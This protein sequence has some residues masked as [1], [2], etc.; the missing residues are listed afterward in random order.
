MQDIEL[1]A[2]QCYEKN[3]KYFSSSQ[4]DL[5]KKIQLFN[6]A[7]A[8]A[9]VHTKYD[10]EYKDNYFDVK[11]LQYEQ[12]LYNEDSI[13]YALAV[14]DKINYNKKSFLFNAILDYHLTDEQIKK[15]QAKTELKQSS[16]KDVLPIMHY[17]MKTAPKTTTMKTIDKFIF[18]GTGLGTHIS[19]I[20]K[21]L[22]SSE[23]LIIED[24]LE[25]FK[26]SLFVTPYYEIAKDANLFFAI[27]QGENDFTKSMSAFL[28]G[29]FY[30]NR[31]IK[32]NHFPN[33]SANKL[34]LIQN[35]LASQTHLTFPYD[36]QLDKYLRP[37]KRIKK[38]YKT[39]NLSKKFPDSILS[40]K[41]IL[42]LAAGPSMKKN[43]NWIKKNKDKYII[44][45]VASVLKSLYDND[46]KPD[47]V[48]HID[49]IVSK[50]NSCMVHYQGFN[51]DE[52]LKDTMFILGPHAPDELLDILNKE[53]VFFFESFTFYHENFG[54]LSS[55][56]IGSTS[57]LLALWLNAKEIY[58]LGLDL[59]LD[60]E[61]GETHSADHEY[62][63]KHDLENSQEINYTISLR[64]NLIPI[65][66]NFRTTVYSTPL[67]HL[68]V[69]SLFHNIPSIKDD[70][71]TMYN[72]NDGAF[73]KDTIPLDIK[74][75]KDKSYTIIDKHLLTK[76]LYEILQNN[77]RI[78]LSKND[79]ESLKRRQAMAKKAKKGFEEYAS[80]EFTN[81]NQY[82]YDM[83]GIVS[84]TLK[85]QGREGNN[86]A[87]VC[88]SYFQYTMPYIMDV[89]NTKEVTKIMKHLK[90][91]DEM[92]INGVNN[93]L[94]LYIK[95]IDDFFKDF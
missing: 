68:S 43:I 51:V 67:L 95:E 46:I 42:I 64:N 54:S 50:G 91:M 11:N 89:T 55:P 16:I 32:Y 75:I 21:K 69:Q 8:D 62:N 26:L 66:G 14:A 82:L 38:A 63:E 35:N 85:L 22:H 83:L 20:D 34:K 79:L 12:Y 52:F 19:A 48:T 58:L 71:Q 57:S 73:F 30:N 94:N 41:P 77:S 56:C 15:I 1:K 81:Q 28:E 87:L 74:K 3:L 33:H 86:L 53:H 6:I 23:Y 4:A 59:A 61:T 60:Q 5:L 93:I 17:A 2:M 44:I 13:K 90:K 7:E 9:L 39:I 49:G 36:V 84:D 45:A 10:L 92:F 18:I 31:Y 72:L 29:S 47:I 70:T 25:L 40:H 24:D 88:S 65:K 80:K 27:S 37:L 76:D 78:K